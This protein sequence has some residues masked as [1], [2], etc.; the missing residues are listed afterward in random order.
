MARNSPHICVNETVGDD[1]GIF[2]GDANTFQ[3]GGYEFLEAIRLYDDHSLHSYV[4][5]PPRIPSRLIAPDS[6]HIGFLPTLPF[7]SERNIRFQV[8][9]R[10]TGTRE[11]LLIR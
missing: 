4:L 11:K 3:N 8:S 2:G 10:Q 1:G 5:A 7:E 6:K 9:R